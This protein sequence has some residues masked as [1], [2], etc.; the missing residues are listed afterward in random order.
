MTAQKEK[1]LLRRK[2]YDAR[3]AVKEK[4]IASQQAVKRLVKLPEYQAA[5]LVLWYVDS[6]NELAT[7]SAIEDA[8]RGD[9]QV[10]IPYCT[11]DEKCQNKL[12]LWKLNSLDELVV[13]KWKILEPPR[14]RWTEPERKV[15]PEELDLVVVPGVA[16]GRDGSRLGKGQGYYDRLLEKVRDDCVL[17]GICF[18]SQLF[19]DIVMEPHDVYLHKVVTEANVYERTVSTPS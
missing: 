6:R 18:E 9:Q 7:K 1:D 17:V 10:V 8:I 5:K 12:G 16:L 11:T 4:E 15:T 14:E 19:T 3:N 13:G 2:A